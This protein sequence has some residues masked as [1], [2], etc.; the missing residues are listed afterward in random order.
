MITSAE[1][2][3]LLTGVLAALSCALLG[4][5]LVLRKMSL[6]GD[7]L[8][9]AVLPGIVIAFLMTN[10]R[11]VIP[12]F[13][14]AA[15]FGILAT[16]LIETFHRRW[17]VQED[18]AIGIV[19]TALFALGVVLVS[20]YTGQVDLDQEC[21]LYGEI[22]Y[23]PWD[24]WVLGDRVMGPRPVWVLG[25]TFVLTVGFIVLF[26]KELQVSSFDPAMAISVGINATV[27]HYALM[28]MVSV[29]TV[30]AFESVGAI[31]VVAMFIVPGATA[32][33]WSNRLRTILWLAAAF[34]VLSAIG[35]Y[36]LASLW[37][38][39]IAG[40]MVAAVGI[41]FLFSVLLSP[42]QGLLGKTLVRTRLSIKVAEDH[43]LLGLIRQSER[44]SFEGVLKR[45]VP[46]LVGAGPWV[47]R[48]AMRKLSG[49]GLVSDEGG[50]VAL[51]S[52]GHRNATRLIRSHRL[53]ESYLNNLGLPQDHTHVPADLLEHFI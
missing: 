35:G 28:T 38:S 32:Y 44:D 17:R 21:V 51:T 7:A 48:A 9:H 11:D 31:L 2:M 18:A 40:A 52:E 4:T 16:I 50:R 39:S 6:L 49:G 42:S 45:E 19:F 36:A 37:N 24:V 20:A 12:M 25:T 29:T 1:A 33:L 47:S 8:S 26:Y 30:A 41:I 34:G 3:I 10:S 13:A 23:T 5:F 14:G 15:V 46:R 43:L 27:M 53:W 22:A